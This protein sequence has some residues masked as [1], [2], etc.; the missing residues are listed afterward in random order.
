M[1]IRLWMLSQAALFEGSSLMVV[2]KATRESVRGPSI[3]TAWPRIWGT[4]V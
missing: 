4:P 3:E 1:D 2:R